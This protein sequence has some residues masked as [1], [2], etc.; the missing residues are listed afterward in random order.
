M[1]NNEEE[2]FFAYLDGLSDGIDLWVHAYAKYIDSGN[3][4]SYSRAI[5]KLFEIESTLSKL[6]VEMIRHATELG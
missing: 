3:T 6:K 4:F 1:I 2:S 5:K